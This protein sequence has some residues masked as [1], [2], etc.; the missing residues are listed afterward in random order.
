MMNRY[1][2]LLVAVLAPSSALALL[3]AG[4]HPIGAVSLAERAPCVGLALLSL[5]LAVAHLRVAPAPSARAQAAMWSGLAIFF[6]VAT[7]ALPRFGAWGLVAALALAATSIA[8][9]VA[10]SGST[11]TVSASPFRRR[12]FA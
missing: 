11:A 2:A 3:I 5:V 6:A 10:A 4:A 1:L 12:I 8:R 7:V 9:L